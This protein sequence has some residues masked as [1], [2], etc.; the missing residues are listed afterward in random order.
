MAFLVT[1]RWGVSVAALCAV[2]AG[3]LIFIIGGSATAAPPYT[4]TY[5]GTP[6]RNAIPGKP[7]TVNYKVTNTGDTV[8]SGV[9]VIF[10]MPDGITHTSVAPANSILIDDTVIWENVPIA[11]GESFYPSLTLVIDTNVPLKTKKSIWVEVTGTDM[12]A[13]S[14]NFSLTAVDK[15]VDKAAAAVVSTNNKVS[16][17]FQLAYS[18]APTTSESSYW[19][20]RYKDKPGLGSLFGA[21][22]Y[23]KILNIKH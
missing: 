12:E 15:I 1:R 13:S 4:V 16:S 6:I 10:H 9:K 8:Y 7:T 22:Q 21:M 18:R 20:G 5:Q 11:V 17:V 19:V 2:T 14:Y 23:H 3:V